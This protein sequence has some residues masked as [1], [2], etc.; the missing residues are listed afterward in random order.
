MISENKTC[1]LKY[2]LEYR[3]LHITYRPAL[4]WQTVKHVSLAKQTQL[5]A[6]FLFIVILNKDITF[7]SDPPHK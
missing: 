4:M 1:R 3:Y 6:V 7:N 2:R 5:V